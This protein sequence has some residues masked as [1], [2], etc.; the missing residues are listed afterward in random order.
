M[1]TKKGFLNLEGG[2]HSIVTPGNKLDVT[3]GSK[4]LCQKSPPSLDNQHVYIL[5]QRGMD[6]VNYRSHIL[7]MLSQV[8]KRS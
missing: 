4:D 5:C 2:S 8:L 7:S 6:A 1:K 3:A